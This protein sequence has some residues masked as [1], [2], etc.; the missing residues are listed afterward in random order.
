MTKLDRNFHLKLY[1]SET[2]SK[3]IISSFL[4]QVRS[5]QQSRV[6]NINHESHKITYSFV[7]ESVFFFKS[8]TNR[9]QKN[10][11]H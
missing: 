11:L 4:V 1:E 10:Y 7:F 8:E 9:L 3:W 5:R 2:C 6:Q